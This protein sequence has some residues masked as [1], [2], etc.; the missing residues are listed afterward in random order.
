MHNRLR[1]VMGA[2]ALLYLGPLF[3]GLGG[4]GW[5][6]V[7]VFVAIFLV[8]TLIMRPQNWPKTAADWS[9]PEALVTLVAQSLMQVLLV[10]LCFGIGR[11]IGGVLGA[12]PPFPL[13]LPIAL[14]F[15]SIPLARLLWDPRKAETMD[16]FLDD[17]IAQ[18]ERGPAPNAAYADQFALTA[19]LLAPVQ[20]LADGTS[21][22]VVAHH[23]RALSAHT[24]HA[25]IRDVLLH[26]AGAGTASRTG[27]RALILHA[28]DPVVAEALAGSGYV[29]RAFAAA[30]QDGG[31]LLLFARRC[32][33]LLQ[34]DDQA[35]W[36]CPQPDLLRHAAATA[37]PETEGALIALAD[38]TVALTPPE[39]TAAR[40]P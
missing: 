38:L 19:R 18:V 5:S 32:A 27:L 33:A 12:L 10:T 35:W 34:E 24:D 40:T 6:V 9:R 7:P 16:R 17:A 29:T 4:F 26:A 36:D 14:S 20:A 13:M 21:D 30:G 2:T 31:L 22:D 1:L 39:E 3:A 8:W 25:V 37:D 11:G 23:V 15:L 28:T